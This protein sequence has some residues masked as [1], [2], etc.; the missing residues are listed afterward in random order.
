MHATQLAPVW[1][2]DTPRLSGLPARSGADFL[3]R[4]ATL[5]VDLSAAVTA[6]DIT[7]DLS[8]Y[9][10]VI[11][12]AN[13]T[14]LPRQVEMLG[15]FV[16]RPARVWSRDELHWAC[17]GQRIAGRAIDVQLSRI[18][19]AAGRDLFRTVRGRGWALHP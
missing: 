6:G 7:V 12:G 19:S 16:A 3:A 14:L 8:T 11:D 2:P 15:L 4:A 10:V 5:Q 13:P 17:W 9:T 18:R 1:R